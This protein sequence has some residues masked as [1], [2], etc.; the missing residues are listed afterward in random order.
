MGL[1]LTGKPLIQHITHAFSRLFQAMSPH[2]HPLSRTMEQCCLNSPF[3]K[4][5]QPLTRIPQ[6][7][8]IYR[9]LRD[10]PPLKALGLD[11]YHALF[12]QSNWPSLGLSI[13]QVIQEVLSGLLSHRPGVSQT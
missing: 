2:L 7:D 3:F 4:H 1:W 9:A 13:I 6:P 11:G 8:E 10:L 12:F 5:A